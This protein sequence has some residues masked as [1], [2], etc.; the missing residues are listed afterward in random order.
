[1]NSCSRDIS[2]LKKPMVISVF[3]PRCWAMF[4]TKAVFPIEGRAAMITRSDG[5]NPDVRASMSTN[6]LGTPV[7]SPLCSCSF[8]M[9]AKLPCTRSRSGT[10]PVW[11]LSSAIAKIC[12]S[13]DAF[14]EAGR[15]KKAADYTAFLDANGLQDAR[16]GVLRALVDTDDAD[17]A[18]IQLFERAVED[19]RHPDT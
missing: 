14:T 4:N 12:C 7:T 19:L 18:V 5:W 8:S 9:V 17:T 16:I 3:T 6:P 13:A 2:R 1:M 15:G 10:K 11:M